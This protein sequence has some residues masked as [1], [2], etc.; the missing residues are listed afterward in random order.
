MVKVLKTVQNTALRIAT[1][2]IQDTHIQHLH[3]ETQILPLYTHLQL[4]AS[5]IRQKSQH[6]THLLHSLTKHTTPTPKKQTAFNN[7]K[8]TTHQDTQKS[9][10]N[11]HQSKHKTH[12]H[13]NSHYLPQQINKLLHTAAPTINTTEATLTKAQ[14]RTLKHNTTLSPL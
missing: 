10:T 5:Q 4:S 8:Y 3:D 1:G 7:N 13:H 12:S 9:H 6:P 2:C 11:T 14:R